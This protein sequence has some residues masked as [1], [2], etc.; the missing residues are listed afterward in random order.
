MISLTLLR[1]QQ[2]KRQGAQ[3]AHKHCSNQHKAACIMQLRRNTVRHPY[4]SERRCGFKENRNEAEGF[5]VRE[6]PTHGDKQQ[7]SQGDDGE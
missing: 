5:E 4:C 3:A 1:K 2:D 6:Q 7:G